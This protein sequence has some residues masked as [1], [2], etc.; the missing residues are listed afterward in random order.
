MKVL[1]LFP[2][3]L[4]CAPSQRFRFEQYLQRLQQHRVKVVTQSFWTAA[5]WKILYQ[6][7]H[8]A[9]KVGHFLQGIARRIFIL[10][11]VPGV[12]FVFLHREAAPAGPP[13]FEW[14]IV[15]VLR[16]RLIYDFDDAIWMPNTSPVNRRASRLKWH[17]KVDTICRWSYRVS[18]GNDFLA[19]YARTF[20]PNVVVIP[21]T[22]DTSFSHNPALFAQ[23]NS[24]RWITLGWTG[25]HSTLPYLE[26]LI[27]VF[28]SLILKFPRLRIII[29][30]DRKPE[31]ALSGVEF[32]RWRNE[33]EIPDLLNIDI[34]VMPLP[35]EPWAKGKCGLKALQFMSL[36]IPVLVSP[37]GVN[38]QLIEPD[39][40]GYWC[41]TALEWEQRLEHLI[42]HPEVR[43]R[44]GKEGRDRVVT[45]YSVEAMLPA[46]LALF[47]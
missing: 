36:G 8:T 5:A 1:F 42:L 32:I 6:Q 47:E 39:V 46:Y 18:C 20:N 23:T 38:T 2:Y 4:M 31:W 19:A 10:F 43:V 14:F 16:K 12:D 17:Q 45:G 24:T 15:R 9:R 21:T 34:G 35:D 29:I 40:S 44:L 11:S 22:I 30:A 3:P 7:G 33:T 13:L 26:P 28:T 25:T 27:P 37:V 41:T